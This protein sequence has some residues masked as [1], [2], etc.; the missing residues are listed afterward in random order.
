MSELTHPA[1]Y[2]LLSFCYCLIHPPLVI[3]SLLVMLVPLQA[4]LL[5]KKN[6]NYATNDEKK[7]FV[8]FLFF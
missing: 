6:P 5:K 3:P 7:V 1:I 4:S 2:A 8:M